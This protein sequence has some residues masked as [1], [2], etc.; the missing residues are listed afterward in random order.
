MDSNRAFE[1]IVQLGN[2]SSKSEKEQ[3][4]REA[5]Q[6]DFFCRIIDY[7]LNPFKTY[8][9]KP[10]AGKS[11]EGSR[12]FDENTWRVLDDL[13]SRKLTGNEAREIV[14]GEID[15][16]F[17]DSAELFR[18][19]IR[20]NL[21]AGV[22]DTTVNKVKKGFI[23]EFPYMRCS[24]PKDAKLETWPWEDGVFS[25]EK[26]DGMFANVDHEY[27]GR[28]SIRSRQ[29]TEF[30]M[31]KFEA[32]AQ[33]IRMHT[34][35]ERQHHG[36]FLVLRDGVVLPRQEGN[37][38][39]NHVI[40]GGDFAENERPVYVIWDQIPLKCVVPKGSYDVPYKERYATLYAQLTGCVDNIRLIPTKVVKSLAEAKKHAVEFMR[41]GKEGSVI[42]HPNAIWRDATSK[43]Q[44]KIKLEFEVD[45]EILGINQGEAGT[46]NE[47]RAA[48]FT[49]ATSDRMLV[50]DVAIKNEKLRDRVDANPEEFIGRILAVVAN[51]ISEPSDSNPLYSLFLGRMVEG[52]YRRDK[53]VADDLARVKAAKHAAIFGEDALK[54]FS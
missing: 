23:P 42:K 4:L 51:D 33:A 34:L 27:G 8:G 2:T 49:C 37:G 47:G 24:L 48:T 5:M 9:I 53:T 45:L 31:E 7:S 6:D 22:S 26:A 52:D 35:H 39:M 3:I 25:Q 30:P 12:M 16:L 10:P 41:A 21:R 28:V 13:I 54:E 32:V 1:I 11:C 17:E 44:V 18:R 19:I 43:E 15:G 20:Q 46:K 29:G 40:D 14:Q 50:V 38:I 36:E